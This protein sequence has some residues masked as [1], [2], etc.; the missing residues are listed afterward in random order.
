[1]DQTDA[2]PNP[3]ESETELDQE[4]LKARIA[5]SLQVRAEIEAFQARF[6]ELDT[7]QTPMPAFTWEQLWR[8]LHHLCQRAELRPI[9]PERISAL[10]RL[11]AWKPAE[12]VLQEILLEAWLMLEEEPDSS[13][14]TREG[15]MS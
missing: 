7:P 13:A 10:R 1:M 5:Y 15:E 3:T 8:Q 2:S 4:N 12:M 9:I 11:S 14:E 6:P